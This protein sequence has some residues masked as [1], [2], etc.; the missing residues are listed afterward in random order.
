MSLF[1]AYRPFEER[2]GQLYFHRAKSGPTYEI[3]GEEKASIALVMKKLRKNMFII[4]GGFALMFVVIIFLLPL[5]LNLNP[6]MAFIVAGLMLGIGVVPFLLMVKLHLTHQKKIRGILGDRRA[7]S[8]E[9]MQQTAPAGAP[10][11]AAKPPPSPEAAKA[12]TTQQATRGMSV[13]KLGAIFLLGIAITTVGAVMLFGGEEMEFRRQLIWWL[14]IVTG[15]L[16]TGLGVYGL[17]IRQK[18]P[19]SPL[20]TPRGDQSDRP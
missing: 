13:G 12:Q 18:P 3:T 1:T 7:I 15:A 10:S 16:L 5:I 19:I 17:I 11:S 6:Q 4:I 9:A 20:P 2:G 14:N 8:P